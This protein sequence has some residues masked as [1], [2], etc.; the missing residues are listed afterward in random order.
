[1]GNTLHHRRGNNF[2]ISITKLLLNDKDVGGE[3]TTNTKEHE[4]SSLECTRILNQVLN[5][6]DINHQI[7][8]SIRKYLH[9]I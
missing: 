9:G 1:M 8:L 7:S 6:K 3:K 2:I 4:M 5:S